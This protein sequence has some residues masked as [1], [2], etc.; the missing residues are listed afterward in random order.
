MVVGRGRGQVLQ[1]VW[2]SLLA[3]GGQVT[4]VELQLGAV[5]IKV[6]ERRDDLGKRGERD[7]RRRREG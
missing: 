5:L 7:E 3:E 6:Q 2:V 4:Y 1:Y